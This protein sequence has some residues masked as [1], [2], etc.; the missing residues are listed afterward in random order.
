M[1][2]LREVQQAFLGRILARGDYDTA[3]LLDPCG[4]RPEE[5]LGIYRGNARETF[6]EA[7]RA[8]F[9]AVAGL[10][11][12]DE[13]R[14]MSW[15][16]QRACP[17]PAGDLFHIGRELPGFLGNALSGTSRWHL[18]EI[19]RLEWLIQTCMVAPSDERCL[20]RAALARVSPARYPELRLRIRRDHGVLSSAAPVFAYW[21]NQQAGIALELPT[22]RSPDRVLVRRAATGIELQRLGCPDYLFLRA[23]ADGASLSAATG[24]ALDEGPGFDLSA[25]LQRWVGSGVISGFTASSEAI[26]QGL[27]T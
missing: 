6:A 15:S 9:P 8:A 10:M 5:S 11:G 23:L 17:S 1:T 19:A 3:F 7:L 2:A 13:F 14:Q 27:L 20:D 18:A 4:L 12:E 25:S 24:A 22:P 16:Y 26:E 21:R